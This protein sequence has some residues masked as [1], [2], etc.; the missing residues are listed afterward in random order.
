MAVDSKLKP[1]Y[2]NLK[3]LQI[4]KY[5]VTEEFNLF[6]IE[7]DIDNEWNIIRNQLDTYQVGSTAIEEEILGVFISDLYYDYPD[8]FEKFILILL[9]LFAKW[10]P[11][12]LDYSAV[13]KNLKELKIDKKSLIAFINNYRKIRESK[14][15][16]IHES[17][18]KSNNNPLIK[19]NTKDV[20]IVHGH[21]VEARLELC[22]LLKN[23]LSLNPIV[24]QDEPN[25]SLETIISKFER[26]AKSCSSAIILF[27]P[28]DNA[29]GNFRARQNVVLELGYF[30]GRFAD[31]DK[32]HIT[33]LKKGNIEIPSDISGILYLEY[34]NNPKE[35]FLDLK[36]QYESWGLK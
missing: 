21:D 8:S 25:E 3:R 26:L 32:R 17:L 20:F 13:V 5:L 4:G 30:L 19:L 27:T 36:K 28:D 14:P 35:I 9:E 10:S 12:K 2:A 6:L 11:I 22:N 29:N 34:S 31:F 7:K 18:K 23:E 33:I 1:I 16:K 15:L 24:L